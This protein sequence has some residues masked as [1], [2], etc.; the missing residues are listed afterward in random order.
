M[1]SHEALARGVALL[2]ELREAVKWA[3]M[4]HGRLNG[5]VIE[6]GADALETIIAALEASQPMLSGGDGFPKTKKKPVDL[7]KLV[8]NL[9]ASAPASSGEAVVERVA[10]EISILAEEDGVEVGILIDLPGGAQIW[11]GDVSRSLFNEQGEIAMD[12][13]GGN[14][15]GVFVMVS[16][17]TST[18]IICRA[19][20]VDN[21]IAIARAMASAALS[22]INEKA[23]G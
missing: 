4:G 16:N 22:A 1:T 11:S 20:S 10:K 7:H 13:L 23:D 14:D 17:N 5:S 8:A 18:E 21:G 2:P 9:E 19:A 15:N 12:S 6:V 3:K